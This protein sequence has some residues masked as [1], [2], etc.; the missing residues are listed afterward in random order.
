[1][2]GQPVNRVFFTPLNTLFTVLTYPYISGIS[3]INI[4]LRLNKRV[5]IIFTLNKKEI[6]E[7]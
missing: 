6:I 1:M 2:L 7:R 3:G 5:R 4:L